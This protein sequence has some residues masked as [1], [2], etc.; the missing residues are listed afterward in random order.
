LGELTL[1][2]AAADAHGLRVNQDGRRRTALELLAYQ[3]VTVARLAVAWPE[4]HGLRADVAEQLEVEA[5]YRGYLER[6]SAEVAAFR[7]EEAMRLPDRLDYAGLSG[8]SGELRQVLDRV[9]PGTLGAAARIPGMT[10]AALTLLYRHVRK[11][12]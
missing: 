3:G 12:A 11:A 2:P 8:L 9:R 5:R 7:R 6:Q 1:S 10:P 4:L